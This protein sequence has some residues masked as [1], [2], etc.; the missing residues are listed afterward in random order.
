MS[1]KMNELLSSVGDLAALV[2]RQQDTIDRLGKRDP[3]LPPIT[4]AE[5][6]RRYAPTRQSEHSF[7]NIRT[8]LAP[9][10]RRLGE[11]DASALTPLAW[12]E[13]RAV[14]ETEPATRGVRKPPC[15]HTLNCEL[16]RAKEMLRFAVKSGLLG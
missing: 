6:Y 7:R 4:I 13:H 5:L 16:G 10:I 14:R 15:A 1:G 11:L 2:R 9:L 12:A 3:V 8:R